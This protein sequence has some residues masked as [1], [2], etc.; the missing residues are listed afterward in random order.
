MIARIVEIAEDGRHLSKDRGFLVVSEGKTELGRV[1]LDDLAAVIG[2]AHGL[3]YSNNLIAALAERC[4]PFVICG[5]HHRPVAFLWAADS[6]HEQSGRISDQ[7]V[8]TK[9]LKKRMWQQIV[10]SKIEQQAATLDAVGR[11]SGGF[12]LLAH[13][14]RAGDPDNMEAQAARRYWPLLF[15]PD[16][17]RDRDA[18]GTNALLN[19]GYAIARAGVARAI[20][21]AGLHPSLGVAH[22][23]RGNAF[24]LVDDCLEPF[25]PIVDLMVF[26]LVEE[27]VAELDSTA[28]QAL[29]RVLIKDM[30]TVNGASP[31]ALCMERLAVS[32]AQCFSGEATKLDLPI[33]PLPLER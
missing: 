24:C 19:Y 28:K 2:N 5:P 3:T 17:R 9:P 1:P 30:L 22:A 12:S 4:V 10:R 20:M 27:G 32:L 11:R 25:R 31:V 13:K 6:H 18:G 7:A 15:G 14:V 33:R 8:A 26:D 16:F 23:N 29:A 21:A